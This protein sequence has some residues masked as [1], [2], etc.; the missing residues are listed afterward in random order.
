MKP[1]TPA[2]ERRRI[3]AL[4]MQLLEHHPFWG[5]LL[6]Q[7]ELVAA[8]DLPALAATDC[9]RT[10]WYNPT[11]T[12]ALS[13]EQ[14]G[15]VLVHEVGHHVQASL[16]REG[17]RNRYLWNC[18][19]D[20]AINRIVAGIQHPARREG[21]Y[22]P[23]PGILLDHRYSGLIAESI[24]ERLVQDGVGPKQAGPTQVTALGMPTQDH[25]GN[26]DV[27]LPLPLSPDE[28]EAL[29]DRVRAAVANWEASDRRGDA[30]G[31]AVR[32]FTSAPPRVPWQRIFQRHVQHAL[33][34]D[35]YD[36]RRPNRRW[37]Q[38][39]LVV[40]GLS[41]ER[42]GTVVVALDTSG[43]MGPDELAEACA[44]IR[45]LASQVEDLRLVV[46]DARV[47]EV[48]EI[49]A[50][51]R[52]LQRGKAKGGGG[53]DHRPV[54]DWI[55]KAR[56]Q[57]DLFIGLTDLYSSFPAQRP[58]FPVLWVTPRAHGNAPFGRVIPVQ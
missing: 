5:Y 53:T 29:A 45:A 10:I 23:P 17:G 33:A 41:G 6:L 57:P 46:A 42:V 34:K 15:F 31:D 39:D 36:P 22:T 56:V 24:Y 38:E 4:R 48:V 43:S 3:A 18:A 13:L 32:A 55:R 47:Q 16:A 54:F 21:M 2:D 7:V 50:L 51:G 19:T 27:H 25:G 44:E 9:R 20:Y 52:W 30:P 49:D 8:D 11:R 12:K 40:P 58:S 28:A 35:A 26:L 14:L 1:K 37:M